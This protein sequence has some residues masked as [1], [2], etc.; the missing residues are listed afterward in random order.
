MLTVCS[1]TSGRRRTECRTPNARAVS[2]LRTA[3]CAL[4]R[5]TPGGLRMNPWESEHMSP[6]LSG[7]FTG[8][9]EVMAG[10]WRRAFGNKTG[11]PNYRYDDYAISVR[12]EARACR[13]SP[14]QIAALIAQHPRRPEPLSVLAEVQQE[15]GKWEECLGT[16]RVLRRNFPQY[17]VGYRFETHMLRKLRKVDE[18]E[19]L[20]LAGMRRFPLA[21]GIFEEYAL[22][23]QERGD[24]TEAL[25]RWANV[26]KRFSDNMWVTLL[27]GRALFAARQYEGADTV[28]SVAVELWPDEWYSWFYHAELA[29]RR[30]NWES[31]A[32]SWE[33]LISRFPGRPDAYP[34][35][36]RA[37][38]MAGDLNAATAHIVT[39][40]FMFPRSADVLK[41]REAIT[42]A[43]GEPGP[44]PE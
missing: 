9:I 36:A 15:E 5:A 25:R 29:E 26:Y 6:T 32:L 40:V 18:A 42:A 12:R 22:A 34:R 44:L 11:E 28:L 2:R 17:V 10:I 33:G 7:I 30:G 3:R 23:A 1:M 14:E 4:L 21:P 27:Y 37:R 35:A 38:R 41:E 13:Y 31:A 39:A 43:G 19:A 16:A 24:W 20:A 8:P